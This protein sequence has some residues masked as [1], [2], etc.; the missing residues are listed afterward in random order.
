M[1]NAMNTSI[2]SPLT[3]GTRV[4]IEKGCAARGV[5]KNVTAQVTDVT[6]LGADYSY[7]VR[8]SLR[9]LNGFGAGKVVRLFASHPNRLAD[10]VVNMNDG[11]PTHRIQVVRR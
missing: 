5:A 4:R 3:V 2:V 10:T 1:N 11:N 8:V 6:P 7:S 9:L